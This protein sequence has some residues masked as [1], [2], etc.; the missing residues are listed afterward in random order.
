[1]QLLIKSIASCGESVTVLTWEEEWRNAPFFENV[2]VVVLKYKPIGVL[3]KVRAI[4]E[5]FFA[6]RKG[7]FSSLVVFSLYLAE[8][9]VFSARA[10]KVKLVLSERVDP[11]FL[12]KEPIHRLLRLF[13]YF[14][15]KVIVFQTES[16]RLYY[17]PVISKK[18]TVIGNP[19]IPRVG[20]TN[21][22]KEKWVI[23]AGRLSE[24]KNFRLLIEAFKKA[25]LDGYTL[26]IYGEGEQERELREF[27]SKNDLVD[28]VFLEGHVKDIS[29][30]LLK[31]DIFVLSSNHEGMPNVLIEAMMC[32]VACVA[33][34][35]PSHAVRT[36]ITHD[37][38]G[39]ITKVGDVREMSDS[40][41]RLAL[42]R[43]LNALVRKNATQVSS[44]YC[45]DKIVQEWRAVL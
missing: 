33:T 35:V 36:L 15:S 28:T 24:E 44:I 34:D 21:Q 32:G 16:N 27:I 19:V 39:L 42:D 5:L 13:V 31:G 17:H 43:S 8:V 14:F 6:L 38:N 11:R 12:P 10:A 26:H 9:A 3:G 30:I 22:D 25:N 41:R 45:I 37:F 1:M 7:R 4:Y 23:A 40:I 29:E 20:A 18:G 2:K